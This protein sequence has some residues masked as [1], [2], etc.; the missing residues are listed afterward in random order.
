MFMK[1]CSDTIKSAK[2]DKDKVDSVMKVIN[3]SYDRLQEK[4]QSAIQLCAHLGNYLIKEL[5]I[6][7]D[8]EDNEQ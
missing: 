1:N 4:V 8:I 5:S 7:L 6:L 3:D 2:A